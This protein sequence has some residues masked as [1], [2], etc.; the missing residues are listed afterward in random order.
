MKPDAYSYFKKRYN[1]LKS[2]LRK[3]KIKPEDKSDVRPELTVE[4]EL[5]EI[6]E[7]LDKNPY[8]E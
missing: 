6:S 1:S 5:K 2:L 3:G 8:W 4:Q 7:W